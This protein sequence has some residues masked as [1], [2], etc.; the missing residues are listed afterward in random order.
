MTPRLHRWRSSKENR[1]RCCDVFDLIGSRLLMRISG[2]F[3]P[4]TTSRFS[5]Q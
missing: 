1:A 5:H 4:P 2:C 3:A